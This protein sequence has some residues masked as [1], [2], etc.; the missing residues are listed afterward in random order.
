M[1]ERG[2]GAVPS[3]PLLLSLLTGFL[4][5]WS[6]LWLG[7]Q[8]S[9]PTGVSPSSAT[10]SVTLASPLPSLGLA[11]PVCTGGW[12][13]RE[14]SSSSDS[15]LCR[16]GLPPRYVSELTLVRV[17]VAEAGFYTM[18][19]SNEDDE[20]QVSFQ[21]QINGEQPST[22][23]SFP[24]PPTPTSSPFLCPP[25]TPR[26]NRGGSPG[27]RRP[28]SSSGSNTGPLLYAYPVLGLSFPS[29]TSWPLGLTSVSQ[30]S[31]IPVP[32]FFLVTHHLNCTTN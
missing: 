7:I 9:K 17:K 10:D 31:V 25:Y 22:L 21:L 24:S 5:Q 2:N 14:R 4:A 18:L 6:C 12:G 28:G 27:L 11:F 26:R 8:E 16:P 23:L 30:T 19:A 13:G 1:E 20:L 3:S 32:R 15:W 29:L